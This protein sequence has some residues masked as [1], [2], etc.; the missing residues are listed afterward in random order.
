MTLACGPSTMS[1]DRGVVC[2]S[3]RRQYD[4]MPTGQRRRRRAPAPA[5]VVRP[6]VPHLAQRAPAA[7]RRPLRGRVRTRP[8][9]AERGGVH[10]CSAS[11]VRARATAAAAGPAPGTASGGSAR[12][13]EGLRGRTRAVTARRRPGRGVADA[14]RRPPRRTR[15]EQH[16]RDQ[17]RTA[18]SHGTWPLPDVPRSATLPITRIA[19]S[20]GPSGSCPPFGGP[21]SSTAPDRRARSTSALDWSSA[22]PRSASAT[23]QRRREPHRTPCVSLASTPRARGPGTASAGAHLRVDVRR[24]PTGPH[25][26]PR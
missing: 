16:G 19:A 2:S 14:R 1:L 10:R 23:D 8:R 15:R 11:R 26:G 5:R 4:T 9:R 25:H 6:S 7:R 18:L 20:A 17:P 3:G 24:P 22:R 12:R 13:G 21:R